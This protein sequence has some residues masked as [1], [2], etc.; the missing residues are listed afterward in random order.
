MTIKKHFNNHTKTEACAP[1]HHW[2]CGLLD[3][4]RASMSEVRYCS[5]TDAHVFILKQS[6]NVPLPQGLAQAHG[7][8]EKTHFLSRS[9]CTHSK[10]IQQNHT[11]GSSHRHT[12]SQLCLFCL[13]KEI[14]PNLPSKMSS[15]L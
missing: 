9:S 7:Y 12:Q 8:Q 5:E 3:P 13:L 14:Q 4:Q 1:L 15:G 11:C 10:N 2:H 6:Y